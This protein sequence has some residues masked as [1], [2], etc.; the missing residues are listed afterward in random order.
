M[1]KTTTFLYFW[2]KFYAMEA[3]EGTTHVPPNFNREAEFRK[4]LM[5]LLE[6]LPQPQKPVEKTVVKE[7]E[8]LVDRIVYIDKP[9]PSN[10]HVCFQEAHEKLFGFGRP[11]DVESAITFYRD[12]ANNSNRIEAMNYL[13]QIYLE[14]KFVTSGKEKRMKLV[15]VAIV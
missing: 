7:V 8:K 2:E 6:M 13:G 9:V 14:G 11:Q 15:S 10:D 5:E 4:S 12:M 3:K 1:S